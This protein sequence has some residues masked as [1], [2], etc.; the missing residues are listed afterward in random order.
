MA[1]R[2]PTMPISPSQLKH[3]AAATVAITI[4]LALF[5]SGGEASVSAQIQATQAKNEL[6]ASEREKLGTTKIESK[7]KVRNP[8][9]GFG[10]DE[11][12]SGGFASGGSAGGGGYSTSQVQQS[13]AAPEPKVLHPPRP[14]ETRTATKP[15][16]GPR[17]RPQPKATKQQED[18][19]LEASRAR[20]SGHSE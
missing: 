1:R 11:G 13:A 19:M 4:L 15:P 5:V 6:V 3:F 20:S 18:A 2:N 7:L 9:A 16:S 10:D 12:G 8:G 17:Q 14:G